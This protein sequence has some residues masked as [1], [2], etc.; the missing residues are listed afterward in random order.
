[1]QQKILV[2]KIFKEVINPGNCFHC[3]LCEGL[4]KNL[5]KMK[6]GE[7]GPQPK[8]L[9]KASS[10]D[11]PDL[12]KI[13]QACPGRG[14][15]YDFLSKKI[16]V[17]KK[18]KVLGNYTNIFIGSSSNKLIRENAS[19]GGIVR[20]LL[21]ELLKSKMVDYVCILD[22][23]KNKILNFDTLI[24]SKISEIIN[25]SQSIY[26]TTPLLHKLKH[27]KK[28]KRYVFVGLPENVASLKV[29]KLYYPEEFKHIK[30]LISIYSGTNMYPGSIEFY[31]KGNGIKNINEVSKLNWRYG[32]WPGKLRIETKNNRIFSLKKFYYNYLIPFFISKSCLITP[33]FT[34]ELSDIS[35]GDAWS[36]KLENKGYGYSV[37]ISRSKFFEKLLKNLQKKNIIRLKK[38]NISSALN[39]HAHMLEFKKI[40]SYLR[41]NKLKIKGPVPLYDL[42]PHYVSKLRLFIEFL[43]EIIIL[44]AA[45]KNIKKI[46]SKVNSNFMGLLFQIIRK[47]WKSL[48]KQTKRKGFRNIKFIKVKNA[49][50]EEF[51]DRKSL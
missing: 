14:F 15:P 1:M 9:R 42:K 6:K 41:L 50:L 37:I 11:I 48:T 4:T 47:F 40:G 45:K 30:Y 23:S 27:L 43:I 34:G 31:L 12:K 39:M 38:A 5:F 49:R 35:V 13:L 16:N 29:L 46:F 19:S 24:T 44:I 28:N 7:K 18:S 3:G 21:I 2:Q 26:Q 33:D 10:K 25:A 8:L 22:E 20:T 32:E 51:Y 36:P 17:E